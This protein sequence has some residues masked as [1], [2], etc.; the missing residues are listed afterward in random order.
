MEAGLHSAEPNL[1]EFLSVYDACWI[2]FVL[3]VPFLT[4]PP[5]QRLMQ[6]LLS[7]SSYPFFP[8]LPKSLSGDELDEKVNNI[9]GRRRPSGRIGLRR[10][11]RAPDHLNQKRYAAVAKRD[12][13]SGPRP[14]PCLYPQPVKHPLRNGLGG[15]DGKGREEGGHNFADGCQVILRRSAKGDNTLG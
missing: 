3:P 11:R 8:P 1:Q 6:A 9:I 5:F 13:P 4:S 10:R 2:F 12:T 14:D 7:F 15:V